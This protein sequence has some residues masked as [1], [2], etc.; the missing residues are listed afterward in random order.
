MNAT[1]NT[2]TATLNV[3]GDI[4]TVEWNGSVWMAPVNGT[5]HARVEQAMRAELEAYLESCGYLVAEMGDE[6]DGML[7]DIKQ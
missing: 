5:Q 2:K 7:A 3:N 1:S 6:I 4:L